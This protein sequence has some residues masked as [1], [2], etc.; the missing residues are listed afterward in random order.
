VLVLGGIGEL[1]DAC[2]MR[3]GCTNNR[4][5][6]GGVELV[7]KR[8][9]ITVAR[10]KGNKILGSTPRAGVSAADCLGVIVVGVVIKKRGNDWLKG[11]LLPTRKDELRGEYG[12]MTKR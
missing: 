5:G 9:S 10:N 11:T 7:G 12:L 6:G 2:A 3:V 8:G 4:G 1:R